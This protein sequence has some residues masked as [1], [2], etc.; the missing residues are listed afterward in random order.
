MDFTVGEVR[1]HSRLT[2]MGPH[3]CTVAAVGPAGTWLCE[4]HSN[5]VVGDS[6][7]V[8]VAPRNRARVTAGPMWLSQL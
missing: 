1:E 3:R 7:I 4:E 6:R 8:E 2:N 5:P